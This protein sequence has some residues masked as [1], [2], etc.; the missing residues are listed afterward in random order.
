ML[1]I[2]KPVRNLISEQNLLLTFIEFDCGSAGM[3]VDYRAS[4]LFLK[5]CSF[6]H[7]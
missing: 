1:R 2:G 6:D 7:L 5:F 4:I 3:I